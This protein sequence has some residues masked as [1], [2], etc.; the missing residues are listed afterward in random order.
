MPFHP[1]A[2]PAGNKKPAVRYGGFGKSSI[3]QI[4]R[5]LHAR[6]A[7]MI[8]RRR[9]IALR[10]WFPIRMARLENIVLKMGFFA[11]AVNTD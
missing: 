2:A 11:Q 10:A 1:S 5:R 9:H 3:L 7:T 4:R 6:L 8:A